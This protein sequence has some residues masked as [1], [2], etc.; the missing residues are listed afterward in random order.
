MVVIDFFL[1]PV[2]ELFD[3]GLESGELVLEEKV[4]LEAFHEFFLFIELLDC[5]IFKVLFLLLKIFDVLASL[6][7]VEMLFSY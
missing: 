1:S 3:A 2:V 5:F 6:I 4:V 7:E